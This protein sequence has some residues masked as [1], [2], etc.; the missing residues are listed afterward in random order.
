MDRRVSATEAKATLLSL[1]DEV[2][3]GEEIEITR[4]GRAVARLVTATGAHALRGR[5]AGVAVSAGD[6]DE[7]FTTG[8]SWD[9]P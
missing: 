8:V 1:L 3:T 9:L 4:H 2:A 7:L 6:D 5:L